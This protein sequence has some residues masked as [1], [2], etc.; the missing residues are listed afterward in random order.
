MTQS[1]MTQS[2]MTQSVMALSILK[3]CKIA[4]YAPFG[5]HNFDIILAV[6]MMSLYRVNGV[7][8]SVVMLRV[9]AP[10]LPAF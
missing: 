7:R 3:L 2:I 6:I 10:K 4:K 8:P 9:V 5:S 1:I